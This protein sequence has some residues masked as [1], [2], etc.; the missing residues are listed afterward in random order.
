MVNP[1]GEAVHCN[2]TTGDHYRKKHDTFK[3]RLFQMFE[4]AGMDAE[5]EVFNLFVGS[6]P[7]EGLSRMETKSQSP[8][9]CT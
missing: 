6:I 7:Q 3:M 9:Y 8:V 5:V 4:W 1:Y 2:I